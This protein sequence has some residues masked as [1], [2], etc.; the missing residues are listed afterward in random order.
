MTCDN[1]YPRM[2][3]HFATII[4]GLAKAMLQSANPADVDVANILLT[5][6]GANNLNEL[7]LLNECVNAWLAGALERHGGLP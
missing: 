1:R 7:G 2:S 5:I 4:D 3:E 6:H